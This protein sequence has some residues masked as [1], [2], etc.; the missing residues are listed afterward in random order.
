M[1]F[2]IDPGNPG[3]GYALTTKEIRG[4]LQDVPVSSVDTGSCLLG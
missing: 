4:L 1:A 2:A 3:T